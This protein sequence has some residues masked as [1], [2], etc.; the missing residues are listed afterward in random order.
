M[1]DYTAIAKPKMEGIYVKLGILCFA[2][3]IPSCQDDTFSFHWH[4]EFLVTIMLFIDLFTFYIC[5][6]AYYAHN[7]K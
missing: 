7:K 6:Y 4:N 3:L 2:Q 1:G 5:R